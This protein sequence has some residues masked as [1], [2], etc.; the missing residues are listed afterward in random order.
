MDSFVSF[1]LVLLLAVSAL[2]VGVASLVEVGG[3][4]LLVVGVA[5]LEAA[6]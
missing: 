1:V 4:F 6:T 2:G 5:S 3:T